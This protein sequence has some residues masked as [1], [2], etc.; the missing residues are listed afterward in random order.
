MIKLENHHFVVPNVV[1][2]GMSM[3]SAC[4]RHRVRN[5]EEYD[6]HC[7][8]WRV[9]WQWRGQVVTTFTN[10]WNLARLLEEKPD[11][12]VDPGSASMDLTN[13]GLKIFKEDIPEGFPKQNLNLLCASDC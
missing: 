4:E 13:Q 6:I 8:P 11:I 2:S 10:W 9:S 3:I 1:G 5:V 7:K 12:T